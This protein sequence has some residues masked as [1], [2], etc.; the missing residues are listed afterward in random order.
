MGFK[1]IDIR[2]LILMESL[3][4]LVGDGIEV[5]AG[6]RSRNGHGGLKG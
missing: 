2:I 6:S 1:S 3:D 5:Y 4:D